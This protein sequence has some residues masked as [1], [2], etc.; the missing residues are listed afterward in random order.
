MNLISIIYVEVDVFGPM[1]VKEGRKVLKRY[2]LLF[3]C[4]SLHAV[5]IELLASL[6]TDSFI[7]GLQ[8][9][10]GRRGAVREIRSYNGTNFVGSENELKKAM[11]E[12]DQKMIGNFL[13]EE[14]C[15]Y[16]IWVVT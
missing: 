6:G 15:D 7:Q 4:F 13:L 14:G 16:M 9:F 3:T 10:I 8:R 2:G 12:L 1:Y 5:H 11:E